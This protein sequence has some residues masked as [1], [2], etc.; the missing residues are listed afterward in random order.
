[1]EGIPVDSSTFLFEVLNLTSFDV[2]KRSV[3]ESYSK[4]SQI[5]RY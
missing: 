4:P 2:A 1:M 3:E 5:E